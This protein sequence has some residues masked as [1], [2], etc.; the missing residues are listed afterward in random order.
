[1]MDITFIGGGNMAT[2]I[3][4]GLCRLPDTHIRVVEPGADKRAMLAERFGVTPLEEP[5][6]AWSADCIVVLAV[7]PQQLKAVCTVLAPRL[8][9]ALVVSIAA[10][11][12]VATLSRWLGGSERIVR[13]MPNTPAMVGKGMSGLYAAPA[14]SESDRQAAEAILQAVGQT[15]WVATEAGID[16]VIAISGSGPAYVFHFVEAL[17]ATGRQLG[18]DEATAR[19]LALATF[20]G[21]IE[22]LRQSGEPAGDLKRKVMSKGGTTERAIA[23]FEADGVAEAIVRG[24]LACRARAVEMSEEFSRS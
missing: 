18:F 6:A 16:D 19:E 1:M 13:V 2:A 23:S 14:V 12:D 15:R 11:V 4:G 5:P 3:I 24:A 20:E 9:G 7:K 21:A 10:G 8:Q 17:E 22:L